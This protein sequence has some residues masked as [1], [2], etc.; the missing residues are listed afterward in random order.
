MVTHLAPQAAKAAQTSEVDGHGVPV[1]HC[2]GVLPMDVRSTTAKKLRAEGIKFEIKPY[3]RFKG[4]VGE[5]AT[6]LFKDPAAT[7]LRSS[8]SRICRH[9]LRSNFYPIFPVF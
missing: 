9:C 4:L 5:Q 7:R 1:L 8:R 3:I 2:G 6:M